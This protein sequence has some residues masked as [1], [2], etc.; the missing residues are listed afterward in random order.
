MNTLSIIIP[1]H[2]GSRFLLETISALTKQIELA[3]RGSV[4]LIVVDSGSSPEESEKTLKISDSLGVKLFAHQDN[5]GY[6]LNVL[7]AIS[8]C[9]SEYFWLVGDDDLPSDYCLK[10]LIEAIDNK[11]FDVAIFSTVHGVDLNAS[12][13]PKLPIE[14]RDELNLFH[15]VVKEP[16]LGAAMSSCIFRRASFLSV[17]LGTFLGLDWIHHSAIMKMAV[18]DK[19][20]TLSRL[21]SQ[22]FI[23][24]N[25]TR[26]TAHFGSQYLAGLRHFESSTR[27]PPGDKGDS[28]RTSMKRSRF[29]TN[30][31][32]TL[33]FGFSLSWQERISAFKFTRQHFGGEPRFWLVDVPVLFFFAAFGPLIVRIASLVKGWIKL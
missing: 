8:H 1:T 5:L 25:S 33:V 24:Q 12:Y 29:K 23:R 18:Q 14:K 31:I 26:W 19:S 22:V 3:P 30:H 7:R 6:D 11:G 27:L 9:D 15:E 10:E 20:F 4:E 28:V 32:D 21:A 17:E 2:D 16:F 13:T